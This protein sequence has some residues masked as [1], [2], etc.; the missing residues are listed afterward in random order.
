MAHATARKHGTIKFADTSIQTHLDNGMCTPIPLKVPKLIM[1]GQ[2]SGIPYLTVPLLGI[3]VYGHGVNKT[4]KPSNGDTQPTVLFDSGAEGVFVIDDTHGTDGTSI[5]QSTPG[6]YTRGATYL[7][8]VGI[9]GGSVFTVVCPPE[10][11]GGSNDWAFQNGQ[12]AFSRQEK[13]D[14]WNFSQMLVLGNVFLSCLS[15]T[16]EL[17]LK[18]LNGDK[19]EEYHAYFMYLDGEGNPARGY[20]GPRA[21]S[22]APQTNT[23][24]L[25]MLPMSKAKL[26][27]WTRDGYAGGVLGDVIKNTKHS[28]DAVK[29]T[30]VT[31]ILKFTTDRH[32]ATESANVHSLPNLQVHFKDCL[33]KMAV[34]DTGSP[35]TIF[36]FDDCEPAGLIYDKCVNKNKCECPNSNETIRNVFSTTIMDKETDL[37]AR[38]PTDCNDPFVDAGCNKNVCCTK[39]CLPKGVGS[40]DTVTCAIAYCT[41]VLSYKPATVNLS[42]VHENLKN[43]PNVHVGHGKTVCDPLDVTGII[44]LSLWDHQIGSGKTTATSFAF[45]ILSHLGQ[46]DG[47]YNNITIAVYRTDASVGGEGVKYGPGRPT[48]PSLRPKGGEVKDTLIP[49]DECKCSDNGLSPPEQ[50]AGERTGRP[51]TVITGGSPFS[52]AIVGGAL[53]L[54]VLLVCLTFSLLFFISSKHQIIHRQ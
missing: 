32:I 23:T 19:K 22:T 24:S 12:L 18:K 15:I 6:I 21:V 1:N 44:G 27:N 35:I 2:K 7:V 20:M 53:F 29:K 40:D 37:T 41:G 13:N 11:R 10:W 54:S 5:L 46:I 17:S 31:L 42:L 33:A 26:P 9:P 8:H 16:Y 38:F 14:K 47:E 45:S 34:L 43:V 30:D 48:T 52:D 28:V 39:C 50:N 36:K 4:W 51:E 3:E 49:P 25:L